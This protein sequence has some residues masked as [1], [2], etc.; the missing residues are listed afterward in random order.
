MLK[1]PA[2]CWTIALRTLGSR[3]TSRRRSKQT[4]EKPGLPLRHWRST[5]ALHAIYAMNEH[6]LDV[7]VR[8]AS[9]ARENCKLEIVSRYRELWTRLDASARQRA[10]RSPIL[11]LDFRFSDEE[12]WRGILAQSA[13]R[14]KSA[15]S[16]T[17]FPA[18]WAAE[19]LRE[20][21]MLAWTTVRSDR[22]AGVFLFGMSPGVA[23]LVAGLTP[24]I[25][26]RLASNYRY[27]LRP[28]WAGFLRYWE[29]LLRAAQ[30][31]SGEALYEVHLYSL[32]LLAAG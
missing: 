5:S 31:T 1:S 29:M 8:L 4:Q 3:T 6:V 28:R 23:Q 21:L 15:P 22:R 11:M 9:S 12:W 7:L 14:R 26:D 19:L 10:A 32:Q 18:K 20:T 17:A 25:I 13:M 16:A 2:V 27:E 24:P 30:A